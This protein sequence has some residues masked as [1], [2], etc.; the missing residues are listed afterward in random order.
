MATVWEAEQLDPPRIVAIKVLNSDFAKSPGD[1]ENFYSEAKIAG[2]LDHENIVTVFEVGCQN[3]VYYYVM[4]LASG[5]D[6]GKWVR[7][8]GH[9]DEMNI[10]TIA[11][12]VAVALQY[13]MAKLGIIHRDIK[14]E[15]IMVDGD[16]TVRLTDLGIARFVRGRDL[17]EGYI[18][19]TPAY[20][21]PE[22]VLC[23]DD[24]DARADIYSLG[25]TM[26]QLITGET[27]FHGHTDDSEVMELQRTASVPDIRVA[28][29]SIS[30]PFAELVACFLAKDRNLR[31]ANWDEALRQIRLVLQ[32]Q[33]PDMPLPPKGASTMEL[34]PESYSERTAAMT[35]PAPV[36]KSTGTSF[37]SDRSVVSKLLRLHPNLFFFLALA[38]ASIFAF[39]LSFFLVSSC[40]D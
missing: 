4:E 14:P 13:A 2:E 6:T 25:A 21:S 19:G 18:S 26:Y 39:V 3:G 8:K 33:P 36:L 30:A 9:L 11:E 29:P 31:P 28:N 32:G 23:A 17:N 34:L 10:L 38:L 5:Y 20:M 27:L 15:N 1:V 37:K 12:S 7:R 40:L 22:Q 16:G 35:E 24:I